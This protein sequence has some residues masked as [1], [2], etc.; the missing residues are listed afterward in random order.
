MTTQITRCLPVCPAKK[1]P[2]KTRPHN[3]LLARSQVWLTVTAFYLLFAPALAAQTQF[4]ST[5]TIDLLDRVAIS[6]SV[7]GVIESITARTGEVVDRGSPLIQLETARLKKQ[8]SVANSEFQALTIKSQNDSQEQ[9]GQARERS[10]LVNVQKLREV[11]TRYNINLPALEIARA[12]SQLKE[13]TSEKQGAQKD[14]KQFR[15]EADAKRNEIE[16]LKF[17]LEKS[18]IRSKY[19]GALAGIEKRPG[20]YVQKGDMIAELYRLDRLSGVVLIGRDQLLPENAAD[21]EGRLEI[22]Q[23]GKRQLFK[24]SI[25]RVFPRVDVD[26][27]YRAFVVLENQKNENGKWRLLPGMVGQATFQLKQKGS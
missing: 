14:L 1:I 22:T 18:T 2:N 5:M 20:E 4:Q 9:I 24:I 26:G 12:E 6:S 21:V 8:L 17:D 19:D 25:R 16:L 11:R 27:K 3:Q 10:A 23:K 13:A 15:Y 7:D